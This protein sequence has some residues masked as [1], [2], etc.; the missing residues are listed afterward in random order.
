LLQ[1]AREPSRPAP[2]D[3]GSSQPQL[4]VAPGPPARAATAADGSV[5][6]E[7]AA[8]PGRVFVFESCLR[9][10][11]GWRTPPNWS[12]AEWAREVNAMAVAAAW[13]AECDYDTSRG[14][15]FAAF[16]RQRILTRVLT[17][18]R[19]E[20]AYAV[21]CPVDLEGD[22]HENGRLD[23]IASPVVPVF[24]GS[25]RHV[26]TRLSKTDRWLLEEFF[27]KGRTEA[28]IARDMGIS[29]QAISKRKRAILRDLRRQLD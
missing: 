23:S 7:S 5:R 24:L 14:V 16:A 25:M 9:R 20:W 4:G 2:V 6:A 12:A 18:Y 13:Q 8:S 11:G 28:N 22:G 3:A 17:R 1:D 10:I 21:R 27:W 19:Q 26:L 29:Q 15:P